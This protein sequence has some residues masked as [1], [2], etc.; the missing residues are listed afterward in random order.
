MAIVLPA[1]PGM[2]VASTVLTDTTCRLLNC[3]ALATPRGISAAASKS[4]FRNRMALALDLIVVSRGVQ[5]H[6][7]DRE[8]GAR[9][10]GQHVRSRWADRAADR[11]QRELDDRACRHTRIGNGDW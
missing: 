1:T 10:F 7:A 3:W 5:R 11:M 6:T 4:D 8:A 9:G 2:T